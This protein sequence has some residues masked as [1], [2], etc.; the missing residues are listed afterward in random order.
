VNRALL[1]KAAQE[2]LVE[3]YEYQAAEKTLRDTP[4]ELLPE[5]RAHLLPKRTVPDGCFVW[6]N[7]LVWL[8]SVLEVVPLSLL[9][10]E[11]EGIIVLRRAR[12]RFQRDH[13]PCPA[14][15]MP[16]EKHA[17]RCRE[18]MEEIKK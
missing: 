12:E 13:P 9:A 10:I 16:N 14:C 8:E 4:P 6:L 18:C 2:F 5:A 15:G 17:L 7:H 11:V 3:G 1:E